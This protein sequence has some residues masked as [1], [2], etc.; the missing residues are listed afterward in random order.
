METIDKIRAGQDVEANTELLRDLCDVMTR[1]RCVPWVGCPT[2]CSALN[3]FPKF[4]SR[5]CHGVR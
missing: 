3:T 4:I 1:G 5:D 2:R